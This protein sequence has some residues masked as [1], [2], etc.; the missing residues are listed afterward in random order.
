MVQASDAAMREVAAAL[1]LTFVPGSVYEHPLMGAIPEFG[2]AC[3]DHRGFTVEL[4]SRR[5]EPSTDRG[6]VLPRPVPLRRRVPRAGALGRSARKA[7]GSG[8]GW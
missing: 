7:L 5:A 3:G 6:R 4:G 8:G 2:R 1:N